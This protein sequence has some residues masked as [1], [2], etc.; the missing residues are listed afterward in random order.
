MEILP[1]V[2]ALMCVHRR[3]NGRNG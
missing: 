2:T 1:L 3:T